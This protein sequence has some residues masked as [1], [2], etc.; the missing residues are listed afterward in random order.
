MRVF[1][2]VVSRVGAPPSAV[3]RLP[4]GAS[5]IHTFAP[6]R[7]FKSRVGGSNQSINWE[8]RQG[9]VRG[10]VILEVGS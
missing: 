7:E 6:I 5:V 9:A 1:Q 8:R 3:S 4:I 2:W 10:P